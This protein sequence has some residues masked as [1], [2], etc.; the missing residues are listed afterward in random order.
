VLRDQLTHKHYILTKTTVLCKAMKCYPFSKTRGSY[1]RKTRTSTKKSTM[2]IMMTIMEQKAR[3]FLNKQSDQLLVRTSSAASSSG[4]WSNFASVS[5]R[6][7]LSTSISSSNWQ[8]EENRMKLSTIQHK[9]KYC[10]KDFKLYHFREGFWTGS[11]KVIIWFW[12][13]YIWAVYVLDFVL[14]AS[15][16]ASISSSNW[17]FEF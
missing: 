8:L 14:R 15:L 5:W 3:L 4:D 11:V 13:V 17:P 6:A 1:F 2:Q 12:V 7:S 9:R 10:L 16:S